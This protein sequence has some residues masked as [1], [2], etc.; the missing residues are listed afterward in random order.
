MTPADN[1]RYAAC[2]GRRPAA[3]QETNEGKAATRRED[4]ERA[5]DVRVRAARQA[6]RLPRGGDRLRTGDGRALRPLRPRNEGRRQSR[7]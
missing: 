1:E 5:H 6:A 4:H 7:Q 3:R 2:R